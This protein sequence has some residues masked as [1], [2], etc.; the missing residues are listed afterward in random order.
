[1]KLNKPRSRQK[2]SAKENEFELPRLTGEEANKLH[3]IELAK[4]AAEEARV[5]VKENEIEMAK[6]TEQEKVAR[7]KIEHENDKEIELARLQF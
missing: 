5:I 4:L 3:D 6:V 2:K 1:M 7:L